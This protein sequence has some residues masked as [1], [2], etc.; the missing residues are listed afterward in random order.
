MRHPGTKNPWLSCDKTV[1]LWNVRWLFQD[2]E[3]RDRLERLEPERAASLEGMQEEICSLFA[4]EAAAY[5]L[6]N[7]ARLKIGYAGGD[8]W[9]EKDMWY[10]AWMAFRSSNPITTGRISSESRTPPIARRQKRRSSGWLRSWKSGRVG[11]S[12][13][14]RRPRLHRVWRHASPRPRS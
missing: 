2:L 14:S 3:T 13:R 12:P 4:D 8:H 6:D 7:P 1:R 5:L 9:P 11:V 10:V